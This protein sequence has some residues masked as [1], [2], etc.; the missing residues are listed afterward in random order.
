MNTLLPTTRVGPW[1]FVASLIIRS[2]R[3]LAN[4]QVEP[5]IAKKCVARVGDETICRGDG[6]RRAS[7]I[8]SFHE[9]RR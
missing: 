7:L 8:P 1:L 3:R 9:G 6:I 5:Q 2:C 4:S